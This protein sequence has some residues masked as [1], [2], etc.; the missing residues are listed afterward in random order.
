[1]VAE[2]D[3]DVLVEG[4]TGVGKELAARAIHGWG[5]RR[6]HPFVP[7]NLAA[8]PLALVESELFGH[9]IGAFP[10]AVRQRTGLIEYANRGTLFLDAIEAIPPEI[11]VK[12]L[13][14]LSEREITPLGANQPRSVDVRIVAAFKTDLAQP[15]TETDLYHRLNV[16]K[17]EIP[18]LRRRREDIPGLFAHFLARA[19]DRARKEPPEIS[20]STRL[21][22]DE[23][24]WPGNIRELAN[25][26]EKL[27]LGLDV[28]AAEHES[29]SQLGL[30]ERLDAYEAELIRRSLAAHNGNVMR[31]M[32]ELKLPKVTFYAHAHRLNINLEAYRPSKGKRSEG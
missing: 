6:N 18:P 19:A 7:I 24:E 23:H 26:A 5:K 32:E 27:A 1:M 8:I 10:G 11:Q 16:V 4:E 28:M 12:L 15:V 22:L 29:P 9:D 17:I 31:V 13:R 14:F 30:R 20:T 3:V 2:A 25:F 21:Y